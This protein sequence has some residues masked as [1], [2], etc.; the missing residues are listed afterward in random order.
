MTEILITDSNLS[1]FAKRLKKSLKRNHN[2]DISLTDATLLIAEM[3]GSKSIYE[4]QEFLKKNLVKQDN[5]QESLSEIVKKSITKHNLSTMQK[6]RRENKISIKKESLKKLT[7]R[8]KELTGLKENSYTSVLPIINEH[9]FL[10][11][12]LLADFFALRKQDE[13]FNYEEWMGNIFDDYDEAKSYFYSYYTIE[14][15]FEDLILNNID[16]IIFHDVVIPIDNLLIEPRYL[17][18]AIA[19]KTLLND[20][21]QAYQN[22]A[23]YVEITFHNAKKIYEVFMNYDDA[24]ETLHRSDSEDLIVIQYLTPLAEKNKNLNPTSSY[25]YIFNNGSLDCH[26]FR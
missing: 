11:L 10:D 12:N 1:R 26:Y 17:K 16:K 15:A 2:D 20:L 3:T 6:V 14:D 9:G 24:I 4:L 5:N 18:Y 23:R 19:E 21:V 22:D 7:P 13:F 8:L 25:Y